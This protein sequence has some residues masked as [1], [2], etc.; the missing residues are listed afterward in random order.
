MHRHFLKHRLSGITYLAQEVAA[1]V[2]EH[3]PMAVT[4][5]WRFT[6]GEARIELKRL[7]LLLDVQNQTY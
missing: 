5:N 4:V 6:T 3:N 2:A 7:Y 1:W